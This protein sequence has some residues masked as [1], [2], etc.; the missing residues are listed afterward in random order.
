ML[1]V[2]RFAALAAVCWCFF[3]GGSP[4][5]AA[6]GEDFPNITCACKACGQ[7]KSDVIGKCPDVCKDKTVYNKGEKVVAPV[8]AKPRSSK[9]DKAAK[10]SEPTEFC[11]AARMKLPKGW[12]RADPPT[13]RTR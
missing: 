2:S 12:M 8:P 6:S 7:N 5:L 1:A 3:A 11:K 13:P 10:V 9:R 4:A